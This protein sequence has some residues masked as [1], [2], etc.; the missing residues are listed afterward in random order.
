MT[1]KENAA[2]L[3]FFV[4]FGA[5]TIVMLVRTFFGLDITDEAYY[6]AEGRTVLEGNLPYALNNSNATGM[7]I[8][9]TPFI[10]LFRLFSPEYEGYFLYM[11]ICFVLFKSVI[12]LIGFYLLKRKISMFYSACIVLFMAA[13][14]IHAIQNFSYNTISLFMVFIVGILLFV[15]QGDGP[16]SKFTRAGFFIAGF[17]SAIAVFAHPAH[18][19]TIVIYIILLVVFRNKPQNIIMYL[20]GG[21]A[22][23]VVL[24]TAVI[25][26]SGWKTF[27]LGLTDFLNGI[28]GVEKPDKPEVM[29]YIWRAYG[30]LWKIMFITFVLSFFIIML[31][32]KKKTGSSWRDLFKDTGKVQARAVYAFYFSIILGLIYIFRQGNVQ[33]VISQVGAC[34]FFVVIVSVIFFFHDAAVWFIGVPYSVFCLVEAFMTAT[35]SPASRFMHVV[36]SLA[37]IFIISSRAQVNIADT[38]KSYIVPTIAVFLVIICE[39]NGLRYV[40]R[41]GSLPELTYQVNEGVYKGIFTSEKNAK[42]TVELENYIKSNTSEGELISFR[43]NVPA[44]YLF[45]NGRICDIR[46]WD[47]MQYSY[48]KNDPSALYAYYERSGNIPDKIIYVDY[49]RD[50]KLSL[51]DNGYLYNE[52]LE[53]HYSLEEDIKLNDT[54]KR[55]V[56]YT[57]KSE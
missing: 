40:Y 54:Y 7:T 36:P 48:G 14:H 21:I 2:K 4:L 39:M 20:L 11:R 34:A 33:N 31:I 44:G 1:K 37:V 3:S 28:G 6:M 47:C 18:A 27:F 13:Y 25:A 22:Q 16:D 17:L 12:L 5:I 32:R 45:M 51:D 26:Q 23:I 55:V 24:F 41:D 29:N 30:H 9:M 56:L 57:R 38:L 50:E 10:A 8:I 53:L 15:L 35:T 19:A 46:T 52:F 43:D 49:G 42:D